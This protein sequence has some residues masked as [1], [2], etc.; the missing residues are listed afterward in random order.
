M[1]R[2]SVP[3]ASASSA[4]SNYTLSTRAALHAIALQSK[5]CLRARAHAMCETP[6]CAP[7]TCCS[8]KLARKALRPVNA[9]VMLLASST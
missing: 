7:C 9:Y 4:L 1:M 6:G 2:H 8:N 3:C 5:Q